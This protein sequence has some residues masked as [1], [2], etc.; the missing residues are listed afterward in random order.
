MI[1]IQ[2]LTLAPGSETLLSE[3]SW[4]IHAQQ[5][6]GL[7]GRNGSGKSSLIRVLIGEA[8]P[9]RGHVKKLPSL[10]IGYLPQS[11]VAGSNKPLWEEAREALVELNTIRSEL[12]QAER[13]AQ[14]GVKDADE[15]LGGLLEQWRSMGGYQEDETIGSTLHGLGF[16]SQDWKKPC[17]S[18]SGGWQMRIAL[19]KLLLS[20][21]D[22]AILDEPTNHL[23]LHARSWLAKHLS[24]AKYGVVVVSHD[25][26]FLDKVISHVVEL[27]DQKVHLYKGNYSQFL[28]LRSER[29]ELEEKQHARLV[30]Q[31]AQLQS[32]IDRFGAK[33]TKAK[34]AQSKKKQLEKLDLPSKA[35]NLTGLPTL[36]I[37]PPLAVSSPLIKFKNVH[38]GWS[39]EQIL[40]EALDL[41]I[42]M[43]MKLALIGP[44][45][46]G[47][48]S[49]IKTLIGELTAQHGH[50]EYGDRLKWGIFQQ[51]IAQELPEEETALSYLH[52]QTPSTPEEIRRSLGA[53][54]LRSEAHLRKIG[55]LSGGERSRIA[56]AKLFLEPHNLLLLDEPSNHLDV[57]S[58]TALASALEA[59]AGTV[60]LISHDRNLII[61]SSTHLG[62]FE[63]KSLTV[64][65]E[66]SHALLE[67]EL[68]VQ[69][70]H[71]GSKKSTDYADRKRKSN[72]LSKL[73]RELAQLEDKLISL[74]EAQEET[75]NQLNQSGVPYDEL[76]KLLEKDQSIT[77]QIEDLMSK[78]EQTG[79][80]LEELSKEL[81][82]S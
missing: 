41:E 10:K 64:Y 12:E 33:A 61:Q 57:E 19:A 31:R 82:H 22:F 72:R 46:C 37:P 62:R 60:I 40:I 78:W 58:A 66:I 47:K 38:V 21:P 55:T 17:S 5:K 1:G 68:A 54:G 8:D 70:K 56:L 80:E 26:Y 20:K 29:M 79:Q 7:I 16:S 65:T 48:S 63:H 30:E 2:H 81:G 25:R 74:E 45:G 73:K 39:K 34:Q 53:L 77:Q 3:V 18:F 59:Y 52:D 4:E 71:L 49:L 24:Q 51:D 35:S 14:E 36:K 13:E 15:R 6:I 50:L 44:N 11:A 27:R 32:F 42:H 43:G 67:P 69:Q 28:T 9:L 76:Q 75:H 23:D